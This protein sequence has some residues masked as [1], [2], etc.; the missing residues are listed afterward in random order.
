MRK[1]NSHGMIPASHGIQ[2]KQTPFIIYSYSNNRNCG[3]MKEEGR[4]DSWE[5]LDWAL[6]SDPKTA[7]THSVIWGKSVCGSGLQFPYQ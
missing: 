7:V 5:T 1:E 3:K 6:L 2:A 4:E